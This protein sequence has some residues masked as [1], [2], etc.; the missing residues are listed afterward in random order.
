ML[1]VI[2][3]G[4]ARSHCQNDNKILIVVDAVIDTVKNIVDDEDDG[5]NAIIMMMKMI[6]IIS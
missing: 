1:L 5:Q 3:D 6:M 4:G 2:I